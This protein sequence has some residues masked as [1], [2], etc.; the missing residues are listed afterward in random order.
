MDDGGA[1]PAESPHGDGGP[2]LD[3]WE[4]RSRRRAI[5]VAVATAL[6]AIAVLAVDASR[7]RA[8][9]RALDPRPDV[10][11]L[12]NL[13]AHVDAYWRPGTRI[14][15][16]RPPAGWAVFN[17]NGAEGAPAIA[18]RSNRL[19][20]S[21]MIDFDAAGAF[22]GALCVFSTPVTPRGPTDTWL[23]SL[24]VGDPVTIADVVARMPVTAITQEDGPSNGR[25][26]DVAPDEDPPFGHALWEFADGWEGWFLTFRDERVLTSGRS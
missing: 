8:V 16:V 7:R 19:S 26:V 12:R 4:R 9:S 11:L 25:K 15:D 22:D 1:H 21:A 2:D 20:A 18:L 5:A 14:E 10:T 3:A 24:S 6:V 17:L 23:R 13:V